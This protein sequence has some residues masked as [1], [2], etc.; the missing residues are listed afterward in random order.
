MK[1]KENIEK[2]Q[3][4]ILE[5]I[6]KLKAKSGKTQKHK[7]QGLP[8]VEDDV[9]IC[10]TEEFLDFLLIKYAKELGFDFNPTK[11]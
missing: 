9:S 1:R 8:K 3:K 6:K 10:P 7:K 11:R 4:E 2:R 5:E